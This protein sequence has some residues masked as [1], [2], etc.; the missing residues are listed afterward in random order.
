M[1]Q[2]IRYIANKPKNYNGEE[3]PAS[4][5]IQYTREDKNQAEQLLNKLYDIY[6]NQ[7]NIT[8]NKRTRYTFKCENVRYKYLFKVIRNN[9]NV[10]DNISL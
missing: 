3:L 10:I 2:V 8:I 6:S 5:S 1:Y 7:K 4:G 9:N